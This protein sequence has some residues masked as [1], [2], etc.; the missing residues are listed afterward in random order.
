MA[1][2]KAGDAPGALRQDGGHTVPGSHKRRELIPS[3]LANR[4]RRRVGSTDEDEGS[5]DQVARIGEG[6]AKARLRAR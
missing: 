3:K 5:D 1:V 2:P 6:I 4:A